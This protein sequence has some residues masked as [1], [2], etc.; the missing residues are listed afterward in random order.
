MRSSKRE[1]GSIVGSPGRAVDTALSDALIPISSL[2]GAPT[3]AG[4]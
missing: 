2:N 1:T 3:E 4:A